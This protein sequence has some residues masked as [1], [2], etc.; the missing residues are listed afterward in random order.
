[1]RDRARLRHPTAAAL[2]ICLAAGVTSVV[3]AIRGN[4]AAPTY[5]AVVALI[6]LRLAVLFARLRT[7]R[8]P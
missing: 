3:F 2:V 4:A 8:R 5:L 7:M 1:M 6:A